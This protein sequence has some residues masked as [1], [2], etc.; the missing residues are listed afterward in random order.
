MSENIWVPLRS[1][2]RR[3]L[4]SV[5][6]RGRKID[7]EVLDVAQSIA[8]RLIPYAERLIGDPSLATSLLEESA[9]IVS[10]SVRRSA[11]L[12]KPPIA[13]LAAYLFPA[14]ISHVN[15]STRKP[16]LVSKSITP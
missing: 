3:R 9:A 5:D 12:N 13:N 10:P 2:A 1:Q 11:L 14:F 6:G 7:P 16:L 15:L 4:H 8:V